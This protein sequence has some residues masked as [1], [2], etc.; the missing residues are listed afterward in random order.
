MLTPQREKGG[1]ATGYGLGLNV[2]VRGGRREAW[3][4]GGQERVSTVLFLLPDD[5]VS[6][7]VLCNLEGVGQELVALGRRLAEIAAA[8]ETT[9][10][11]PR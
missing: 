7:A 1:R 6:V 10:A 11:P 8:A 2:L 9:V 3:H 5:G 4:T